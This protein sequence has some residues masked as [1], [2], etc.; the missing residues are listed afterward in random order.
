MERTYSYS[1]LPGRF[2]RVE[3][4]E[5]AEL[6]VKNDKEITKPK[7]K[8]DTDWRVMNN[9]FRAHLSLSNKPGTEH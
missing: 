3:G 1:C 2:Q 8:R 9:F 4:K 5:T 6:G 7:L